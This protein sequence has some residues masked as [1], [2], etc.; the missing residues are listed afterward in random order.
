VNEG[1]VGQ[2]GVTDAAATGSQL[3]SG[4]LIVVAFAGVVLFIALVVAPASGASG[5]CGG[6]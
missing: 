4:L 5:G 2:E 6:G 1:W 3:W